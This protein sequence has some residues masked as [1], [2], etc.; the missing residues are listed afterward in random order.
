VKGTEGQGSAT[1][2]P[3]RPEPVEGLHAASTSSARTVSREDRQSA[4]DRMKTRRARMD[5]VAAAQPPSVRP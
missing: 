1:T 5:G 2:A 3:V 4:K